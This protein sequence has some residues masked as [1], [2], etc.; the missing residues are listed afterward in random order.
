MV[1]TFPQKPDPSLDAALKK[2][3][4][5]SLKPSIK[6]TF[7]DDAS[8]KRLNDYAYYMRLFTGEHFDA[9]NIK[10]D[11]PIYSREYSKLR[12]VT[13]NFAGLISKI[14]A[15]M[16]F[17]EPPVIKTEDGDQEFIDALWRENK[18]GIQCYESALTN[19]VLGDAV[20]KIRTG[21]RNPNDTDSTVIIE[22]ITPNIYFPNI[23]G[24]NVRAEPNSQ[25]LAWTFE[26]NG[27]TYLRVEEHTP[28]LITNKVFYME[29]NVIKNEE[30]LSILRI[31]GL[32]PT[33]ETGV[34]KS[35]IVHIPNW[36]IG[37]Q[38]FGIS[39]YSDLDSIFYA[40]NNRMTKVDNILDKHGDP[41]LAVPPGVLDENGRV[42]KHSLGV[43]ELG[44]GEEGK[45]EY[46]VWDAKLE[47]A[48][49]EIEKLMDFMYL[50]GEISPDIIGLGEGK[51]DSGRALKFKLMRTIAKTARKRLYYDYAI[52][53][54]LY[55]AQL[56]AK[57]WKLPVD[58]LYL[59][60]EAVV[61]DIQWQDGLPIDNGEQIETESK[62]LDA[63]ITSKKDVIMRVYGV[64]EET[65]EE[66]L[67]QIES[68][69][70]KIEVPMMRIGE[71]DKV[72][73]PKTGKPPKP[74]LNNK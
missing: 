62:A 52:K 43:I 42:R 71:N 8:K 1:D 36:K 47:S 10:I 34:E 57:E 2:E 46:I 73:D 33:Q 64:D 24:F 68:E 59:S 50:I 58:G 13:V 7:P 22:D 74:D 51:T 11:D 49:S 6:E 66:Q 19:S 23:D 61:P 4:S 54:V 41:I 3:Q 12:Y 29:N 27:K 21:K 53:Q 35:L 44:E 16:L 45:P 55:I 37:S 60:K 5:Q 38:Y 65:A 17:S 70:P 39:D 28:G 69:Q 14:L 26:R 31:P 72:V 40:I 15:D 25:K 20:F 63:G 18:L 56:V 9:F 48:F 67:D 30:S 32:M